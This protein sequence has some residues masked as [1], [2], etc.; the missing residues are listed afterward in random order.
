MPQG[1][2]ATIVGLVRRVVGAVEYS[3]EGSHLSAVGRP[4]MVSP[5]ERY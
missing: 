4:S 2:L 3:L 5:G 1:M